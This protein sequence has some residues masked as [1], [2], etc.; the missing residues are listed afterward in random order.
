MNIFGFATKL[1]KNPFVLIQF[2]IT[3]KNTNL[4]HFQIPKISLPSAHSHLTLESEL[5]E[6]LCKLNIL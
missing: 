5:Q 6:K 2:I 3:E 1:E 4:I